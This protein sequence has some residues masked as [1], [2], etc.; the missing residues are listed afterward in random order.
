[1]RMVSNYSLPIRSPHQQGSKRCRACAWDLRFRE[2]ICAFPD[3]VCDGRAND[4]S[5]VVVSVRVFVA[6]HFSLRSLFII[7]PC[8]RVAAV[9][10]TQSPPISGMLS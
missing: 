9:R 2:Q 4:E 5:S 10:S 1:M 8:H 3:G 6:V 7:T